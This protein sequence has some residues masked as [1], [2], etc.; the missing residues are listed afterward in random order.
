MIRPAPGLSRRTVLT[1]V[2]RLVALTLGIDTHNHI[3][4]PLSEGT[5]SD[6]VVDLASERRRSGLTAL[7]MTFAIDYQPL[8]NL[9]DGYTRFLN[10]LSARDR[11]LSATA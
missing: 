6:P 11:P 1:P 8:V 7:C 3:D 10:G 4:V 9:G 2:A 5:E